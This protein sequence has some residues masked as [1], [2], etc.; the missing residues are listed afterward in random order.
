MSDWES[1]DFRT[2]KGLP[3]RRRWPVVL[4]T[5]V[6]MAS[7]AGGVWLVFRPGQPVPSEVT[8][9]VTS[10]IQVTVSVSVTATVSA[11]DNPLV[12]AIEIPEPPA[13]T[14]PPATTHKT[15]QPATTAPAPPPAT[16]AAPPAAAG[17]K[18]L[19]V[20]CVR[21]G[22]SFTS[23]VTFSTGGLA[24]NL[25]VKIGPV[26]AQP[27]PIAVKAGSSAAQAFATITAA[28]Q[29]CTARLETSAGSDSASTTSG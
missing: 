25:Y 27:Y 11:T 18:I 29:T 6:L 19:S 28:P 2:D 1:L 10:P 22:A 20:T 24:G 15:T 8:D 16:T 21:D 5:V 4:V 17:P 7:A 3:G 14:R 12:T 23:N 26:N 9:T 13:P